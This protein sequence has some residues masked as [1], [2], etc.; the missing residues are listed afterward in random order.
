[1]PASCL[2]VVTKGLVIEAA[3]G[4][5]I[6]QADQQEWGRFSPQTSGEG[7]SRRRKAWLSKLLLVS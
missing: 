5:L 7:Q 4:L 1:M 6:E 2:I 3:A